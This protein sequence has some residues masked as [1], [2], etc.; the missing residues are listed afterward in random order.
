MNE[1]RLTPGEDR[2][3][4][5]DSDR[6]PQEGPA[7][8]VPFDVGDAPGLSALDGDD[9][10]NAPA[11]LGPSAEDRSAIG[12]SI[13][14]AD[15]GA[16]ARLAD[17]RIVHG[18]LLTMTPG[19]RRAIEHG[20]TTALNRLE[21]DLERELAEGTPAAPRDARRRTAPTVDA[22]P[23]LHRHHRRMIAL[24]RLMPITILAVAFL[25]FAQFVVQNP[26]AEAAAAASLEGVVRAAE[27]AGP[28]RYLMTLERDAPPPHATRRGI[29][30][31]G[32]QGRFLV[33]FGPPQRPPVEAFGFDGEHY[34][35]FSRNG[36]VRRSADDR[37]LSM[38]SDLGEVT[39]LLIVDRLLHRLRRDYNIVVE[40]I[41]AEGG[42]RVTRFT[43]VHR[44][45]P[46][47]RAARSP[48][49]D[50]VVFETN[51]A[52]RLVTRL[53]ANWLPMA[54]RPLPHRIREMRFEL[55]GDDAPPRARNW[56]EHRRHLDEP[57]EVIDDP[58][59]PPRRRRL[60]P[61]SGLRTPGI[62][63]DAR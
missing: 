30:D 26:S 42:A 39:S 61:R 36:P 20:I 23:P 59:P 43:A 28:R 16:L 15:A 35:I 25:L 60:G 51:G 12:S 9:V 14:A 46:G 18:V 1:P 63:S 19:A 55:L 3:G 6:D 4:A 22:A 21:R 57:R 53:K 44:I 50:E 33:R 2:D 41:G 40:E 27:R 54:D 29:V 10:P 62:T 31:I 13:S 52:S 8:R 48:G 56:F 49:P 7:R 24:A 11:S 34:W 5:R 47:E 38:R 32:P 17:E 45:P 58:M 37:L